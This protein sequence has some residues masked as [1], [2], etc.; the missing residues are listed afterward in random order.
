MTNPVRLRFSDD[1]SLLFV[2]IRPQ[3]VKGGRL[4][5]EELLEALLEVG[6][7]S[8]QFELD[9]HT[10][11]DLVQ[12]HWDQLNRE[13]VKCL[14]RRIEFELQVQISE[15]QMQAWA[16]VKPAFAGEE[17]ALERLLEK[18]AYAGVKQGYVYE[19]L[20]EIMTHSQAEELLVARGAW[21][22]HGEH[23]WLEPLFQRT[24]A[25]IP[26]ALVVPLEP[27]V[28][29]VKLHPATPG[30]AGM[31]VTGQILPAQPGKNL[32]LVPSLG[33]DFSPVDPQM[34]VS[35]QMGCPVVR[36]NSVR[37]DPI[38]TVENVD[39]QSGDLN[40]SGS[41][42]ILG[43]VQSGYRVQA[44]GHLEILGDVGGARLE[45]GG[46]ILIHGEVIGQGQCLIRAAGQIA[47]TRLSQVLMEGARDIR[48]RE[49]V[50]QSHLRAGR[51]ILI[52]E[53]PET[54]L[55][56]GGRAVALKQ[57]CVGQIGNERKSLSH[58]HLGQD[59][60]FLDQF[61]AKNHAL[62]EVRQELDNTL[63]KLIQVRSQTVPLVNP[64]LLQ[65]KLHHL[66]QQVEQ[67]RDELSF[68]EQTLFAWPWGENLRLGKSL[69]P[70]L[71][72]SIGP[73]QATFSAPLQ[74]PLSFFLA[75]D[76]KQK[77]I[78][79]VPDSVALVAPDE[80]IPPEPHR[81]ESLHIPP[82]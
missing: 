50:S 24:W 77:E 75:D 23:A 5:A 59:D 13:I 43:S 28:P 58:V 31:T 71:T 42:L 61:E 39:E 18:L 26:S 69:W 10:F 64:E 27:G 52:G 16:T 22:V 44:K 2:V 47:V 19:A 60:Y 33:S 35:T 7:S 20:R 51:S 40:Y 41:I 21:P 68:L 30:E 9:Q 4:E 65:R 1:K 15:D 53:T 6:Y 3:D 55:L 37:L 56:L 63:K 12:L 80:A 67:L 8:F 46:D 25:E 66:E 49:A 57:V 48:V 76:G 72:I 29:L 14:A 36:F 34:L 81:A 45:A 17:I 70:E 78:R 73:Y 54:G 32:Q 74:G 79:A 82:H 11:D 62:A 38:L